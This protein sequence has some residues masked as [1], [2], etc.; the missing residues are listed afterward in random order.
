MKRTF[1]QC[2]KVLLD[3]DADPAAPGGAVTLAL[4]GSWDHTGAC[5]WPHHTS[6]EW[7]ERKGTARVVFVA[8]DSDENHVRGLINRALAGGEC[9]GPDGKV[10]CWK[11]T[12][13]SVGV[14]SDSEK[15]GPSRGA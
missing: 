15:A 13:C 9:T 7:D 8:E 10:S 11:T 3:Q 2:A 1:V 4:C 6:V 14:L 12:E 5:R